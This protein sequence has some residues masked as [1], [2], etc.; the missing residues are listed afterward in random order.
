MKKT[1]NEKRIRRKLHLRKKLWGTG[2]AP[3][4]SVFR[5]NRYLY[6][7]AVDDDLSKVIVGICEKKMIKSGEKPVERAARI[8]EEFGKG[9]MKKKIN[10]IVFDR[11]GYKFHGRV[12][13]FAEGIRKAGINF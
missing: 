5:S 3:R 12:K 2:S 9:L 7:G 4:V 8:G 10:K 6:A 13:A 1:K 11:S